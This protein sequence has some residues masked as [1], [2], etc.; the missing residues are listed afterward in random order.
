MVLKRYGINWYEIVSKYTNVNFLEG[1]SEGSSI[2]CSV[3]PYDC[4]VLGWWSESDTPPTTLQNP[5][6]SSRANKSCMQ[7]HPSSS[8]EHEYMM[9]SATS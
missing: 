2:K 7:A 6:A 5:I 4:E 3:F 9:R 1:V 8:N